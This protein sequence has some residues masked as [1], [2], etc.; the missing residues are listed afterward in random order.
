M[1]LRRK[2]FCLKI[3][4]VVITSFLFVSLNEWQQALEVHP[5]RRV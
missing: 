2:V 1:W 5:W 3:E 4:D